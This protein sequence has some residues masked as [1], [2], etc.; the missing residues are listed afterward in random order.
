MAALEV[1][2]V[3]ATKKRLENEQDIQAD[4]MDRQEKAGKEV[5]DILEKYNVELAADIHMFGSGNSMK[6]S[7]NIAVVAKRPVQ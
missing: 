2:K 5:R 7:I 6:Q 4:M 3:A 1:V